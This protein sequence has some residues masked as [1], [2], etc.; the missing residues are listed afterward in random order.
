M[1]KYFATPLWAIHTTRGVQDV[2]KWVPKGTRGPLTSCMLHASGGAL[3]GHTIMPQHVK[4]LPPL[5]LLSGDHGA[6]VPVGMKVFLTLCFLQVMLVP[7]SC[8]VFGR[9]A[10]RTGKPENVRTCQQYA[11]TPWARNCSEPFLTVPSTRDAPTIHVY[12]AVLA[13]VPVCQDRSRTILNDSGL[14]LLHR[15]IPKSYCFTGFATI[16]YWLCFVMLTY[17]QCCHVVMTLFSEL[18]RF[19]TESKNHRRTFPKHSVSVA[20]GRAN[21]TIYGMWPWLTSL[22]TCSL[23]IWRRRWPHVTGM[24]LLFAGV[25]RGSWQQRYI[26]SPLVLL[27]HRH[28]YS[29]NSQYSFQDLQYRFQD[30][31]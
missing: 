31:F 7:C 20:R 13:L 28:S 24:F 27:H 2:L 29:T 18:G 25:M 3:W 17:G 22:S 8:H 30:G 4:C 21:R 11:Q 14:F 12:N 16:S 15:Y 10:L 19:E 1:L 6:W 26:E 9:R 23:A 5:H